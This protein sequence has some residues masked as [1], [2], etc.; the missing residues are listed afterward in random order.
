MAEHLRPEANGAGRGPGIRVKKQLGR[1]ATHPLWGIVRTRG[2]IAV[3]LARN[4]SGDEAMPHPGVAVKQRDP[5]LGAGTVKEAQN[6]PVG[7]T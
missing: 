6:H 4:D 7:D 1:V 3:G 2:A 5:G